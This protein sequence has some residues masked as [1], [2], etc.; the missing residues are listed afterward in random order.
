VGN[1]DCNIISGVWVIP[2]PVARPGVTTWYSF[3]SEY[4]GHH[5][6]L[7]ELIS[8]A[9]GEFED[10]EAYLHPAT[11]QWNR[12]MRVSERVD[13]SALVAA[14]DA[15][16]GDGDDDHGAAL[17]PAESI[18]Q[19]TAEVAALREAQ[20]A[21]GKTAAAAAA[22][23][24]SIAAEM[25]A[26]TSSALSEVQAKLEQCE[27]SQ[28]EL[29]QRL[30]GRLVL[31]TAAEIDAEVNRVAPRDCD[32]S[33]ITAT[34]NFM[35]SSAALARTASDAAP[36]RDRGG[37]GRARSHLRSVP[38]LIH[39]EHTRFGNVFETSI[40]V[41]TTRMNPRRGGSASR[42]GDQAEG[43]AGVHEAAL[44]LP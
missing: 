19:L 26:K 42:G 17:V 31:Y 4:P 44:L 32:C 5:P 25:L 29:A 13:A 41:A 3:R 28:S 16:D 18:E 6:D 40:S 2:P 27:R 35:E 37:G 1:R 23:A 33:A 43:P 10:G 8:A 36:P 20:A 22:G 15:G 39:F 30:Y 34:E 11:E 14:D 12:V 38:P 7:H 9:V 24:P 21:L